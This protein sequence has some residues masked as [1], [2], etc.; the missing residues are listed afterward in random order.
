VFIFCTPFESGPLPTAEL[1][2]CQ[3]LHFTSQL[4]CGVVDCFTAG[5]KSQGLV[6]YGSFTDSVLTEV[7]LES[8]C[9]IHKAKG[10][11]VHGHVMQTYRGSKSRC[12]L[13]L[14]L[15]TTGK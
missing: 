9:Y 14:N 7:V 8:Q 1:N 3:G 13:F 12:P 6:I 5:D 15:C 11:V 2:V 4:H 10:N